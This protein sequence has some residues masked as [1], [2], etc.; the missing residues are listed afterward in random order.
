MELRWSLPAAE[1][2]FAGNQHITVTTIRQL[3]L[4]VR[5]SDRSPSRAFGLE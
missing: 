2:L 3:I 5:G 1:D 4:E